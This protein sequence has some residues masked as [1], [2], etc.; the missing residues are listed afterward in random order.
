VVQLYVR[1]VVSTVTRPVK[2]LRGFQKISLAPGE[3]KT[4]R[5]TLLPEDLALHGHDMTL[6]VE[7][8]AFNVMVGS[9]SEQIRLR[10]SFVVR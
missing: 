4:V 10:G 3:K 8:G 2:E 1:D 6:H 9:S 5:L 7:P